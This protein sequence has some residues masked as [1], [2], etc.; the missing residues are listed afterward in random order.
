MELEDLTKHISKEDFITLLEN[1]GFQNMELS[2]YRAI[3]L[4]FIEPEYEWMKWL[5]IILT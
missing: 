1:F 4:G 2:F 5:T 3:E